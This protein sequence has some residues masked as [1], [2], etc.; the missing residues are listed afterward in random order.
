MR[1]CGGNRAE[2]R[3]TAVW[4]GASVQCGAGVGAVL[5]GAGRGAVWCGAGRGRAASFT[6]LL[7]KPV[8][9]NLSF[10]IPPSVNTSA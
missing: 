6:F 5:C 10:A 1:G 7:S 2:W 4:A 3:I 9:Q 8:S